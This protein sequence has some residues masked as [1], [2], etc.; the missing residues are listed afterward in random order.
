LAD[1]AWTLL[2]DARGAEGLRAVEAELSALTTVVAIVGDVSE[3][4]HREDLRAAAERLGGL[5]LLVN[6]ASILGPSPQPPLAAYPLDVL[7]E[8][9][10]VNVLAP[11]ALAQLTLPL[12]RRP[13]GTVV[14]ITSD[15]AV[16]P[17]EG[18][19]G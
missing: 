8:V 6:N 2:I 15:A 19:G 3:A 16:E 12:L 9:Y 14:D 18:W 7:A 1:R 17:Y 4:G 11:L 10:L 5:D 13:G